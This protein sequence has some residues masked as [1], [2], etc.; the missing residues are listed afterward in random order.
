MKLFIVVFILL[1]VAVVAIALSRRHQSP[2]AANAQGQGLLDKKVR[3]RAPLDADIDDF[4]APYQTALQA[5]KKQV[6]NITLEAMKNDDVF[7]S[8]VGGMA[9]WPEGEPY[10]AD[11]DGKPLFLL[12]QIRFDE[13]PAMPGYPGSG[14][15][16]F[17]IADTD[18]YGANFDGE[19]SEH[20]LQIQ[21][22][23]RVKYWPQLHD[24][25]L[26][27]AMRDSDTLPHDP[28]KPRRMTFRMQDTFISS[29]DF[30]FDGIFGGDF[31]AVAERY[32]ATKGIKSDDLPEKIWERFLGNGHKIGGYPFFTQT[33]PRNKPGLELLLQLDSDDDMM[34]GDVG[35]G[36]FFISADDL[37]RR[38]FSRVL[39]N[40]DCH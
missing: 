3:G 28:K 19:F 9:Y 37:Q 10:P 12:A 29:S 32:A 5:T 2:V 26:S 1:L 24:A 13:M 15:L 23:F 30:R 7:V 21:K 18:Y 31:N 4:L 22:D 38:D 27:V 34:W 14:M 36:G 33:D 11:S 16:Q 25:T 8:K 39:Y 35:V 40:W 6:A 17:F 20:E